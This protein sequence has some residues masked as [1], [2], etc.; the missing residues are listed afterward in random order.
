M[1][2]KAAATAER[3]EFADLLETLTDEQW[4]TPSLC[5]GW[6]VRDVAAHV[7]SYSGARAGETAGRV[8]RGGGLLGR[9]NAVGVRDCRELEPAELVARVRLHA[10]PRGVNAA[11]GG[12]VGLVDTLV[13]HQDVR[14]PLGLVRTVPPDRLACALRFAY[15]APVLRGFWH[16]RGVRVSAPEVG[17]A[18]GRGPLA[19]GPAEAVLM[20]VA[21]RSGAAADLTGPGAAVLVRRLG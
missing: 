16:A 20:A 12:R 11:F 3:H 9:V 15:A 17:W 2:V 18:A 7:A 14:R 4:A 1:D 5:A 8:V 6:T 13:H 21:G 19:E 10:R